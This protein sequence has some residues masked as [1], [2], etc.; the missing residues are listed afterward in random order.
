MTIAKNM[1]T[2]KPMTLE[3]YLDYDDGTDHQRYELWDGVLVEM[4][5]ESDINVVIASLLAYVFSQLV[6]YYRVHRGTEIVVDGRLANTRYPDLVVITKEGAKALLGKK[7]SIVLLEM[8][9]PMLAIEVVS[10]SDTDKRWRS[11]SSGESR[12]RD[13]INKRKEYAQRGILEYWII[14]PI[15]EVILI[16]SLVGQMYQEQKFVKDEKLVSPEFPQLDL[17][18]AQVLKA[19]L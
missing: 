6:P 16:L 4:D 14:D 2:T 1:L 17:S 13:Y 3:K 19:G 10:S 5:T 15:E 9:A 7:R 18:A 8:P 11:L 12:D